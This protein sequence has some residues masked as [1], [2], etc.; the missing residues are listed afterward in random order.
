[1]EF[2]TVA[3]NVAIILAFAIPGFVFIKTKFLKPDAIPYFAK[4][5]L[6]F[7][8]PCLSLY[9]FQKVVYTK[10]LFL[11]MLIF[12]AMSCVLQIFVILLLRVIYTK[13]KAEPKFR[14]ASVA[15]VLG[16]V[17]FV[18]IPLIE[19]LLPDHPEAV[20]YAATFIITLNVIS[21]TI[22]AYII[23]GDKSF[24]RPKKI[25]LNPPVLTLFISLPLFFT[26]TVLP[27]VLMNFITIPAKFTTALC[28]IILG[29]RFACADLKKM[30][31]EP[32]VYVSTA[33]K[34]VIFPLLAFLITHWLPIYPVMKI[35]L[36]ILCS[37]PSASVI[38]ALSEIK[39][40]GGQIYAANTILMTT[41]F[42]MITIPLLLLLV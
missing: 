22:G 39:D 34:L 20:A 1:M 42:C 13:R 7:C 9:S 5:L 11:N 6:Y 40:S 27:D 25:L 26:K 35:T 24:V 3:I 29:M 8:Q 30:F 41:L 36:F 23:T 33:V 31:T 2:G 19:A 28:M 12:M 16:N 10:E 14:I 17:G 37:C 21:W 15:P 32:T 18:G 38:L 4:L